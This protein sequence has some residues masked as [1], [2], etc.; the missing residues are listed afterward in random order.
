[1][2]TEILD[3]LE[4]A[5]TQVRPPIA[6]M[7]SAFTVSLFDR[8]VKEY[9]PALRNLPRNSWD[10]DRITYSQNLRRF[11]EGGLEFNV[12]NRDNEARGLTADL[13]VLRMDVLEREA[14]KYAVDVTAS[15]KH[16]ISAKLESLD[17][18]DSIQV[19]EDGCEFDLTGTRGGRQILIRQRVK[20]NCRY[21]GR[22]GYTHFYQ[23][24]ALIYVDG[25]R[26][27][28]KEYKAAF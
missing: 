21:G 20:H 19:R 5:L 1:M 24:P 25:K 6:R 8:M 13:C 17:S 11:V 10:R 26:M 12:W 14:M 18:I 9:G 7:F 15:A 23:F 3:A 27:S 22:T 16:K 2:K 4:S 28:E